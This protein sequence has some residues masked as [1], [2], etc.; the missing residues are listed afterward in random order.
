MGTR[1]TRAENAETTMAN[2]EYDGGNTDDDDD[3]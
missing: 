3:E 2:T 1:K